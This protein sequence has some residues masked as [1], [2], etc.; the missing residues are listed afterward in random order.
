MS[1]TSLISFPVNMLVEGM[2]V[3]KDVVLGNGKIL[4]KAGTPLDRESIGILQFEGITEVMM[5]DS[6]RNKLNSAGSGSGLSSSALIKKQ[7][8]FHDCIDDTY[9]QVLFNTVCELEAKETVRG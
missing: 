1:S 7:R 3:S 6:E 8:M 9:M 5:T 2:V 4:I